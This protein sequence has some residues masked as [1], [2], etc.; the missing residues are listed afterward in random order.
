M[1]ALWKLLMLPLLLLPFSLKAQFT[2]TTNNG[3]ITITE[4]NG[5]GGAVEIPG[6][7]NGLPVTSVGDWAFSYFYA[8]GITSVTIPDSVI[9]IGNYAFYYADLTSV[10]IGTNVTGIGTSAFAYCSGLPNIRIPPSVAAIGSFAFG[11]CANLTAITV[12]TQNPLFSSL[13]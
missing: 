6:K 5:P 13:N 1:C 12:D 11:G 9:T 4:Y 7:I 10:E 2:F 8:S 3:T